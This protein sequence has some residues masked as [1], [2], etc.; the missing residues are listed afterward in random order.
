MPETYAK[1]HR[2]VTFGRFTRHEVTIGA[3]SV[4]RYSPSPLNGP[5]AIRVQFGRQFATIDMDDASP[6]EWDADE[7]MWVE[8]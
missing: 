2:P 3:G 1:L 7:Q 8:S 4:V 5:C 6:V